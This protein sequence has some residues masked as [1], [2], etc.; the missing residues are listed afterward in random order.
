MVLHWSLHKFSGTWWLLLC[1][2]PRIPRATGTYYV[3]TKFLYV[4]TK[5]LLSTSLYIFFSN[6]FH[7]WFLEWT[8][9]FLFSPVD[10][11]M[12]FCY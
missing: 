12:W 10:E 9:K 11:H 3:E 5:F 4:D 6:V 2:H 7:V 1:M 8:H